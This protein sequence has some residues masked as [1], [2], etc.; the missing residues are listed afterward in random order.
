MDIQIE[1][2]RIFPIYEE[3]LEFYAHQLQMLVYLYRKHKY[4]K[5]DKQLRAINE[6]EYYAKKK[7][8]KN[9][10]ALIMNANEIISK[11]TPSD[12]SLPWLPI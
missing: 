6:L 1:P 5:D 9:Y 2:K 10:G 11:D 12:D 3:D 4:I 7:K 8:K